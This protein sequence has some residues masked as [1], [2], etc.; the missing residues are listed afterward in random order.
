MVV[1]MLKLK[2]QNFKETK[3]ALCSASIDILHG[4]VR[5]TL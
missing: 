1:W 5:V 4:I 3:K 2:L